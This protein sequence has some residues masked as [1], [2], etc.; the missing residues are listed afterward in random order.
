MISMRTP[1]CCKKHMCRW[2]VQLRLCWWSFS[3][4]EELSV[5]AFDSIRLLLFRTQHRDGHFALNSV[6]VSKLRNCIG[7]L[8]KE[9]STGSY[10][11]IWSGK[12]CDVICKHVFGTPTP[13]VA[14]VV[15]WRAIA[16]KQVAA[17]GCFD[18]GDIRVHC[19]ASLDV[20]IR[21]PIG[22]IGAKQLLVGGI[23]IHLKKIESQ[24]GWLF[25][26]YG[27]I[28]KQIQTTNQVG[29]WVIS[30]VLVLTSKAQHSPDLTAGT[31]TGQDMS[32]RER[33]L[34]MCNELPNRGS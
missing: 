24:L 9:P 15:F 26:I 1:F 21:D 16:A 14:P 32:R 6:E 5:Q 25:W 18:P 11:I 12:C 34:I 23:P 10:R 7:R 30:Y 33:T 19:W 27:N 4:R 31:H 22:I 17:R 28:K 20:Y 3:R 13:H 2:I 29:L 8:S